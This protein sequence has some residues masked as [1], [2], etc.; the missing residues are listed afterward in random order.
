MGT[1]V[2]EDS[3]VVG[4]AGCN[5]ED[6]QQ[7]MAV[8]SSPLVEDSCSADYNQVGSQ[9]EMAVADSPLRVAVVEGSGPADY[10]QLDREAR[11]V[12]HRLYYPHSVLAVMLKW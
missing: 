7:K 10:N 5:Q 6:S 12:A 1:A 8:L 9:S 2:V 3:L 11:R 4:R